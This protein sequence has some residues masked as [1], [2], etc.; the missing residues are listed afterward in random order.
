MATRRRSGPAPDVDA[1]VV[2]AGH[3]GLVAANLLADR[4]WSVLV[5]EAADHPGGAVHSDDSLRPGFVTDWYSSFYPLAAASPTLQ[6]LELE[7]WGLTWKHA[8]AVL[9]HVFPDGRC[10]LLDRDRDVTAAS[11]E[12]FGAGDGDSWLRVVA[13]YE[14]I[15]EPFLES[16]LS[17]FPP[18]RAATRLFR[19]MGTAD[20]MR[21][22]RFAM[23]PVRRFGKENFRGEGATMLFAGNALHTDLPPESAGSAIYGWLLCMLGQT[24]GFPVPAGGSRGIIDALVARLTAHGGSLRFGAQVTS[25]DVAEGQARGVR[26]ADGERITAGAVLA[27]VAAPTLYT[28][29][30]GARHLPDRLNDD[31]RAFDWDHS[32]L[33][34]NWALSGP[35]PW[36]APEARRAGTVH[37]GVDLDGLSRYATDLTTGRMPE[38][39]FALFGQMTTSDASRSPEGTESA[40]SYT[41]LPG[42]VEAGPDE[43]AR[44]VERVEAAIEAQAPGFGALVLDRAVQSPADL[45]AA[46]ANLVHGALGGGTAAIHQELFFRPVPGLGRADTVVDGLY[47]ASASAH[48]GGGVHGTPG[49]NAAAAALR[50]AGHA[51]PVH[52]AVV[53]AAHRRIY[54]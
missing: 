38:Q 30:V 18:V 6:K 21:F 46:D 53:D 49:A 45:N 16:A 28:D 5:L 32:T 25:V 17:P 13:A 35:V 43:I 22:A 11:L 19:T 24:V 10:A 15:A 39:P 40:W 1:V 12:T 34:L 7:Q 47:L 27:D 4:G 3:N 9:A 31:L 41:H 26:L 33:K 36:T 29:L 44:Q 42:S 54:R 8:P 14:R 37:L 2:G 48:P 23:S 50:R 52:R 51:G 20:A